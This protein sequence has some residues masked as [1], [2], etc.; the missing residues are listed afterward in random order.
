MP[1]P[2]HT[3]PGEATDYGRTL[4]VIDRLGLGAVVIPPLVDD[5]TVLT[6]QTLE[7]LEAPPGSPPLPAVFKYLSTIFSLMPNL[8]TMYVIAFNDE[9][10]RLFDTE[11][12]AHGKLVNIG[13]LTVDAVLASYPQVPRWMTLGLDYGGGIG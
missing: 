9:D 11:G 5:I 7:Q 10:I 4:A 3:P 13:T 12:K 6:G 8:M 2:K 1:N